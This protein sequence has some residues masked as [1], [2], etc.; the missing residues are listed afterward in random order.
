MSDMNGKI[1]KNISRQISG[2]I[3]ISPPQQ[4]SPQDS[5]LLPRE[6]SQSHSAVQFS[7]DVVDITSHQNN[8]HRYSEG[9][10]GEENTLLP[11]PES[12]PGDDSSIC[13]FSSVSTTGTGYTITMSPGYD[14]ILAELSQSEKKA[15]YVAREILTSEQT[16]IDVLDLLTV[17]F[18]NAIRRYEDTLKHPV[19]PPQD[20]VMH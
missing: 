19:I 1:V 17:D 7:P 6:K 2:P 13:S 3:L 16:F 20:L 11:R 18:P 15:F 9:S 4:D 10:I 5:K 12:E 14:S 8:R